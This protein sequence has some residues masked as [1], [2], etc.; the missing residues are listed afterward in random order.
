MLLYLILLLVLVPIVELVILL[1]VHHALASHWGSGVSLLM[2]V[3][4]I[5]VT[6]V[7]GATLARQQGLSVFHDF[8]R[9]LRSGRLPGR[10]L[11]DGMLILLGGALLLTPGFLTDV[12][13][14]SLLFPLSRAVYRKLLRRW[15][16]RK[17]QSGDIKISILNE[18]TA[19][20]ER[21]QTIEATAKPLKGS[22]MSDEDDR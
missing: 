15:Y 20:D 22:E 8:Q 14:L 1:Q 19:V 3:G 4:A 9:Q 5:I 12:L 17:F 2:T 11:A 21:D 18:A 16:Q 10:P 7:H 6:G 13:G